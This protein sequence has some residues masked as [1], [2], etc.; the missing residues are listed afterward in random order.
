MDIGKPKKVHEIEPIDEPIPETPAPEPEPAE[1]PVKV[2][3]RGVP[4]FVS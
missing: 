2:P 1:E 3:A 4:E